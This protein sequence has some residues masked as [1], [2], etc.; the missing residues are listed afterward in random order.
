MGGGCGGCGGDGLFIVFAYNNICKIPCI[1]C[2]CVCAC[3][4]VRVCARG[5]QRRTE[6]RREEKRREVKLSQAAELQSFC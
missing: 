3:V 6:R 4:R 1:V 5:G 2:V